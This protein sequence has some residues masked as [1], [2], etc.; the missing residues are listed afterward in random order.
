MTTI[1]SFPVRLTMVQTKA[2]PHCQLGG[3]GLIG[4]R[5]YYLGVRWSLPFGV[6]AAAA[7][8]AI[9]G[10]RSRR[11]RAHQSAV[12]SQRQRGVTQFLLKS[13]AHPTHSPTHPPPRL[14]QMFQVKFAVKVEA[15]ATAEDVTKLRVKQVSWE[16]T[17]RDLLN[18]TAITAPT[19]SPAHRLCH[20]FHSVAAQ[21]HP[22]RPWCG[23]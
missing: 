13:P 19:D 3:V 17:R 18:P 6:N 2:P 16:H 20:L 4:P 21:D 23:V 8:A 5:H 7:M 1:P 14:P 15:A 22:Q 9:C 11:L 10:G 12:C